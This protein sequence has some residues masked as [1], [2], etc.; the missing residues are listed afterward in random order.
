MLSHVVSCYRQ[1]VIADN[2]T[3]R[4]VWLPSPPPL[5][6]TLVDDTEIL[7]ISARHGYAGI[8]RWER[9]M[10]LPVRPCPTLFLSWLDAS[11]DT[12]ASL[13]R[14]LQEHVHVDE[15]IVAQA[16]RAVCRAIDTAM[17]E[18]A[19]HLDIPGAAW[20]R[21]MH[22]LAIC[23]TPHYAAPSS[24]SSSS[25]SSSHRRWWWHCLGAPVY[26]KDPAV[27]C[28]ECVKEY[29]HVRGIHIPS[30]SGG[31]ISVRISE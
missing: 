5:P 18:H 29:E 3:T 24:P 7:M 11:C 25:S 27:E 31:T 20:D 9:M 23:Q 10:T 8:G 12:A 17:C 13:C 30:G 21:R 14:E 19:R 2:R 22:T 28:V 15:R 26:S 6:A 1:D 16:L 4:V